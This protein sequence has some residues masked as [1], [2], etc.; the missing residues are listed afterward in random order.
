MNALERKVESQESTIA[1]LKSRASSYGAMPMTSLAAVGVGAL[2][3]G[4][5]DE[6]SRA[7]GGGPL[8]RFAAGAAIVGGYA[9][10][11][12]V[13]VALGVGMAVDLLRSAG[14]T[15]AG[16]VMPPSSAAAPAPSPTP[17]Q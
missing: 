9:V 13:V 1:R 5:V 8:S 16:Q 4:A 11:S 10:K 7:R 12:P 3:G 17:A 2:V 15:I 14:A 6:F